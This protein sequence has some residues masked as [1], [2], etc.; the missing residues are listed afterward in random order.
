MPKDIFEKRNSR[1]DVSYALRC[2]Q[3]AR[4]RD[5]VQCSGWL[6]VAAMWMVKAF[7]ENDFEN[8]ATN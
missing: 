2:E 5:R 8:H 6:D 3:V 1:E 4:E 7:H